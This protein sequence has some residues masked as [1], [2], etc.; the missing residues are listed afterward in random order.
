MEDRTAP[1]YEYDPLSALGARLGMG[2]LTVTYTADGMHVVRNDDPEVWDKIT[3]RPRAK[4][5]GR[6]W[7]WTGRGEPIAEADGLHL[8]DAVLYVETYLRPP[9]AAEAS[10]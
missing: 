5:G 4:D 8:E 3:C 6:M 7:Y 9:E 1:P 2:D 10:S